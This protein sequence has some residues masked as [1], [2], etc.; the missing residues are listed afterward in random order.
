MKADRRWWN[1]GRL[2]ADLALL[3]EGRWGRPDPIEAPPYR[4][5]CE[6]IAEQLL[7]LARMHWPTFY[8]L[9]LTSR[10]IQVV[11]EGRT[12]LPITALTV[13]LIDS[14]QNVRGLCLAVLR[15]VTWRSA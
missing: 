12:G 6:P 11:A 3:R 14:P 7:E 9:R 10:G 2:E 5:P 15:E 13:E 1:D 4:T 8:T